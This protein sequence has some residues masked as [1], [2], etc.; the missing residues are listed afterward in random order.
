MSP[1]AGRWPIE[2]RSRRSGRT[3]LGGGERLSSGEVVLGTG[4]AY[5]SPWVLWAWGDG[6]D[7]AAD[8]LH[9]ELRPAA[10]GVEPVIFDATG[11]GV[12]RP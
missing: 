4:E 5:H 6:L 11:P 3:Y 10:A 9:A 8:R 2:P 12:R 1:S 7:A